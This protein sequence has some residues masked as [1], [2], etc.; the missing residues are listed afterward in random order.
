MQ[1]AP[2]LGEMEAEAE[3]NLDLV[4]RLATCKFNDLSQGFKERLSS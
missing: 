4:L 1:P 3:G 2:Q